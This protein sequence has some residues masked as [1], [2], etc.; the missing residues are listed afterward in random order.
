MSHKSKRERTKPAL[1]EVKA[2]KMPEPSAKPDRAPNIADAANATT[3]LQDSENPAPPQA[4]AEY[5]D[6]ASVSQ[7]I[8]W[9]DLVD[10]MQL[11]GLVRELARNSSVSNFNGKIIDLSV[12]PQ[13][14]NLRGERL[15]SGLEKALK[16]QLNMDVSIRLSVVEPDTLDTPAKRM[17]AAEKARQAAAEQNIA[18]DP[19]V[20]ALQSEFGATIETVSPK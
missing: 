11:D 6:D 9:I 1:A 3:S 15:I 7:A 19:S 10:K 2:A 8:D 12:E 17:S 18:D 20:Q 13:H 5:F 14:E 16:Q 4:D